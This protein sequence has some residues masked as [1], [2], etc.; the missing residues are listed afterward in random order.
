MKNKYPEY[1]EYLK[2]AGFLEDDSN[3]NAREINKILSYFSVSEDFIN[4]FRDQIDWEHLILT[5]TLSEDFIENNLD[6]IEIQL[7]FSFHTLSEDFLLTY[8]SEERLWTILSLKQ[9]LSQEF[10]ER[11]ADK[12]DWSALSY[13]A[14]LKNVKDETL[15]KHKSKLILKEHD[16]NALYSL[17]DLKEIE[18]LKNC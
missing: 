8:A 15:L 16:N 13:N 7:L 11:N 5:Q 14:S 10:I 18:F 6:K 9:K 2:E 17:D 4:E 3:F 12:V 1:I